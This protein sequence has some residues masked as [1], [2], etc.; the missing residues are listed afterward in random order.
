MSALPSGLAI[1]GYASLFGIA[2]LAGDVVERGAFAE[3]LATL[4]APSLRMLFQHDPARPVGRWSSAVEDETGLWV[5]GELDA[6]APSALEVARLVQVGR[7][8]GLSIG[9]RTLSATARPGGGRVLHAIDLRE[10]SI[11]AFPMLP[12]ARLRLARPATPFLAA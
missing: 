12:R 6:R 4:P 8:D 2:D 5:E 11:V 10:V 3:S 7:M 9:F 1:A